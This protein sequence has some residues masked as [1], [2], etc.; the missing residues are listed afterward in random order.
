MNLNVGGNSFSVKKAGHR[1]Y[2]VELLHMESHLYSVFVK[3]VV[4]PENT[5]TSNMF[6]YSFPEYMSET[7]SA[8][9]HLNVPSDGTQTF[10]LE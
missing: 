3:Y 7:W 6:R 9:V 5:A 8:L 4:W 10:P 2:F 1:Q